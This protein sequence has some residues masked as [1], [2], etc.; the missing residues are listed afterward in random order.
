MNKSNPR[1]GPEV[2]KYHSREDEHHAERG[3]QA[4]ALVEHYRADQRRHDGL[5]GGHDGGPAGLEAGEA[6]GVEQVGQ[7]AGDDAGAEREGD[8][9]AGGR[10]GLEHA[11]HAPDERRAHGGEQAGVEV[12]RVARVAALE[13]EAR[14]D[15]VHRVAEAR[16]EA[17]EYARGGERHAPG[18]EPGHQ[19]AAE[20]GQHY[21]GYL[22]RRQPLLEEQRGEERDDRRR[23]VEQYRG[24]GEA[25]ERHGLEVAEGEKQQAHDAAAEEAP[26]VAQ[27][28]LELRRTGE[29]QRQAE[30]YGGHAAAEHDDPGGG[31]ARLAH[32]AAEEAHEA[33]EA[34]C[35]EYGD[36]VCVLFHPMS[37][38]IQL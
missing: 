3:E 25:H 35:G 8:V 10:G 23:G 24:G 19:R 31:E 17:V 32:V 13:G 9:P 11:V 29:E 27:L 38:P 12:Y 28:Y 1:P 14:E 15:A 16:A 21:G 33:P 7:I 37:P 5:D 2:Q 22:H 6:V 20:E 36:G 26:E 30:A 34:A 18:A 4:H